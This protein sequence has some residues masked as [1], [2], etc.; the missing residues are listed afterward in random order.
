MK[1][2]H[3]FHR[4]LVILMAA[5]LAGGASLTGIEARSSSLAAAQELPPA[6]AQPFTGAQ[7]D[8]SLPAMDAILAQ[9]QAEEYN[10]TWDEHTALPELPAAYQAPNRAN[11]FRT[12][13]TQTGPVIIPRQLQD[14]EPLPWRWG[15]S[16]A[17]W[18]YGAPEQPA[19]RPGLPWPTCCLRTAYRAAK[20]G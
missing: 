17:G 9:I 13:F 7:S 5:W 20:P 6:A 11:G 10:I 1:T 3:V 4:I 2:G 15:V 12:Y 18:G 8:N 16:L 14:G 19:G